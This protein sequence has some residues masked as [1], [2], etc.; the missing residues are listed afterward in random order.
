MFSF[1]LSELFPSMQDKAMAQELAAQSCQALRPDDSILGA[2]V[3]ADE[4]DRYVVRVFCGERRFEP[5]YPRL[6]PWRECLIF[7]VT[8]DK[9]SVEPIMS[10]E[11][12]PTIR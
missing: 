5:E 1:L 3:C 10:R 7:A 9:F 2:I 12:Q 6:P 8:K 11:Y 4:P